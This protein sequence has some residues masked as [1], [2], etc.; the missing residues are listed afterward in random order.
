[1]PLFVIYIYIYIYLKSHNIS[2]FYFRLVSFIWKAHIPKRVYIFYIHINVFIHCIEL[3]LM[4]ASFIQT[5]CSTDIVHWCFDTILEIARSESTRI[6]SIYIININ[7]TALFRIAK[8]P[9][10][11]F[12]LWLLI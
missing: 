2:A 3:R 7:S 1:M 9:A 11:S 10:L 12:S 5:I 8:A 4:I 6:V